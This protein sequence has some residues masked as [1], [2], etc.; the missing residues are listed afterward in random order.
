MANQYATAAEAALF[1]PS[2]AGRSD[3]ELNAALTAASRWIDG[4]CS[5]RFW[6]DPAVTDRQF[7]VD[8]WYLLELGDHEI[9][10]TT[11]VVVKVDD[12]TGTFPTTISA[13]AYQLE[14]VNAPY[15]ATG[16]APYTRVRA[17]STTWPIAYSPTSR[18]ETVKIT[19]CYGWP[20]I[21]AAVTD[22]CLTLTVDNF[23][24][25]SGVGSE[26]ID[27]YSVSYTVGAKS[28]AERSLSFYRRPVLV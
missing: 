7:C 28:A 19:A 25:P 17:L 4:Y 2:L 23:E 1:S 8:D 3:F 14:P 6:L 22:A 27:G 13:S 24:N 16:V 21:P 12:G 10:T 11:G 26:A 9:G 18:Q 15:A 5:R 20:E